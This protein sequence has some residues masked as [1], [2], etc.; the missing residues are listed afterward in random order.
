MQSVK[1]PCESWL[2]V[3]IFKVEEKQKDGSLLVN[4]LY[5][6]DGDNYY[7]KIHIQGSNATERKKHP[8]YSLLRELIQ[9][10]MASL[11]VKVKGYFK[12]GIY[13]SPT[14]PNLST[15]LH[16]TSIQELDLDLM[17]EE[18]FDEF[19]CLPVKNYEESRGSSTG[20]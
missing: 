2:E 16:V 20:P 6:V 10:S 17:G 3:R 19:D 8:L 11:Q 15:R 1:I 14:G 18:S 13:K 9:C 4:A 12:V 7:T 5:T